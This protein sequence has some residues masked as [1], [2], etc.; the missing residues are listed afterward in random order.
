VELSVC[1]ENTDA[2]EVHWITGMGRW[3]RKPRTRSILVPMQDWT[4]LPGALK[5]IADRKTFDYAQKSLHDPP[6]NQPDNVLIDR[7][8]SLLARKKKLTSRLLDRSRTTP[9]PGCCKERFG[10]LSHLY[11]LLNYKHTDTV[12]TRDK[13]RLQSAGQD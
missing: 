9:S 5:P 4:V 6:Q 2:R 7:V 8:R 11:E 3:T 12:Q 10:S 13:T 1:P